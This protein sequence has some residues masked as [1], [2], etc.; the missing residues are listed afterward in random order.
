MNT[1]TRAVGLVAFVPLVAWSAVSTV[2]AID[3]TD[4]SPPGTT[5]TSEQRVYA[6]NF[7]DPHVIADGDTFYAYAT[8]GDAGNMPVIRSS[9]LHTWEPAGDA[10]PELATWVFAGRTWAPGVIA[11][12]DSFIA[13][14][15]AAQLGTGLQCVGRAI[16][17]DPEGPFIDDT[18]APLVCQQDEGGSIDASPFRASDGSLYLYW[19]NDGNCCGLDTWLYGQR[20]AADGLSL[21][22][23]PVRLLVQDAEWEGSLI[24][25]PFMWRH[26]DQLYLFYSGN[27]FD[28]A[29]YAAGYATC[30]GPLGPCEKAAENPILS[31]SAVAEGPGHNSVLEVDGRTWIVYHAWPPDFFAPSDVR[32]M[33]ISELIWRDGRPV[34]DG[35]R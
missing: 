22:G 24:E 7:P 13:F 30:D 25:A 27:A 8:N 34:V 11:V 15:T 23:E 6:E 14:Y 4:P 21:T 12:D 16:A 20:L 9:D 3:D 19:K 17:D 26:D 31:T 33:W 18:D 10:M 35:P 32:T 28:S 29:D 2:T 1:A 5:P